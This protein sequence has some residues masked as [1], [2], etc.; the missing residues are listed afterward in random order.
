MRVKKLMIFL[1]SAAVLVAIVASR[2]HHTQEIR[3]GTAG[4]GGTYAAYGTALSEIFHRAQPDRNFKVKSTAGSVANLRLLADQY[5]E[6]AIT[7]SNAASDAYSGIGLFQDHPLTGYSAVSSLYTEACQIIVRADSAIQT[8]DDLLGKTISIGEEG[9]GDLYHAQSILECCG[10]PLD[11]LEIRYLSY[12]DALQ[13]LGNGTIDAF[14]CTTAAPL[15]AVTGLSQTVP[16][17]LLSLNDHQVERLS[18]AHRAYFPLTVPAKTYPDQEQDVLTIG[19]RAILVASDH[20]SQE[21]VYTLLSA[22]QQ[23][24]GVVQSAAKA[25]TEWTPENAA[26]GV[27]IPFHPGAIQ[28]FEEQ[29]ISLTEGRIE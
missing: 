25:D 15:Q 4:P 16:V 7:Q 20:L 22:L 12:T 8:T 6:L 9:S 24:S 18:K 26:L 21:E 29:G 5:L 2:I 19:V 27:T 3:I 14:F 17:R 10:L 13:A 1:V 28:F 23:N 11:L